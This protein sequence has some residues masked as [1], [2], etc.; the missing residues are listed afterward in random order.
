MGKG[1]NACF[2]GSYFSKNCQV[3]GL[4]LSE[5]PADSYETLHIFKILPDKF[6]YRAVTSLPEEFQTAL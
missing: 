2:L 3:L 6:I 1:D 5:F 4:G